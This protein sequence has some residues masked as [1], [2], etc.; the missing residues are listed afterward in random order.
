M[1]INPNAS[2]PCRSGQIAENCCFPS[3][4]PVA[5]TGTRIKGASIEASITDG[6]NRYKL[7]DRS[8]LS[9]TVNQPYQQDISIE[10]RLNAFMDVFL[11]PAGLSQLQAWNWINIRGHAIEQ[12]GDSIY[13]VRYHQRQFLYRLSRVYSEQV[14]GF[15]PPKGNASL[16]INDIPLKAELEAFLLR[17]TSSMDSLAKVICVSNNLKLINFKELL[18]LNSICDNLALNIAIKNVL[19]HADKWLV[20]LKKF[21]NVVAHEGDC[22]SFIGVSHKGLLVND[23]KI[24]G[25]PAGSY[26]IKTWQQLLAA[27]DDIVQTYAR[28][29]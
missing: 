18:K 25:V 28:T 26:V 16:I 19:H 15:E 3:I 24:G 1:F 21:R 11:P 4:A 12:F 6:V 27:I 29:S 5:S 17:I 13:A 8:N 9:I 23:A 2:C 14:F 20:P 10:R 22:K 7:P